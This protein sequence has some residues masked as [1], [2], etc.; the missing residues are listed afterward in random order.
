MKTYYVE[1][2]PPHGEKQRGWCEKFTSCAEAVYHMKHSLDLKLGWHAVLF[3]IE[4]QHLKIKT[5]GG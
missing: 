3:S 2:M 4:I 1:L 5:G